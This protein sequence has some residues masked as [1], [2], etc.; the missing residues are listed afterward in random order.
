MNRGIASSLVA[1]VL[2][3]A[4]AT[5]AFQGGPS[6][7]ASA[8]IDEVRATRLAPDEYRDQFDPLFLA[9][10]AAVGPA[11]SITGDPDLDDRIRAIA[12]SR[13]Y[14]RQPEPS[15]DLVVVD[16]VRLQPPAAASWTALKSAAAAAGH[17]LVLRSGYRSH[18]DQRVI[19][20]GKLTDRSDAGIDRRLQTSAAPGY[21]KHHTGYAVDIT[22]SGWTI[23]SF[24]GSPGYTW[25][26][27][28]DFANAKAHGWI[29]SYPE[30]ASAQGPEPEPWELVWVG[31]TNILCGAF[32][33]RDDRTFCDTWDRSQ[34][35]DIEWL[36][37]E[38]ITNGCTPVRFCIDAPVTRAE[39]V[40]ML[41][42]F[43]CEPPALSDSPFLDVDGDRYYGIPVAWAS[44][45]QVTTGIDPSRFG[46]D[47]RSSRA[48]S[49]TFLW[50][51]AGR[52]SPTTPSPFA[53]V[54]PLSFYS[55]AVDWAH[56]TGVV[57]GTD[58]ITFDPDRPLTRGEAASLIRRLAGT[59]VVA[60]S[61]CTAS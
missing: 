23:F 10:L 35:D 7:S 19:F 13:G 6:A 8:F 22:Q 12:E 31:A 40:T 47:L 28:D 50:R 61:G 57:R 33:P 44:G 30:G 18:A 15:R 16:G 59:G 26:A 5:S 37:A 48:Q 32:D 56:G 46:P 45:S 27:A 43:S 38:G 20:T 60:R 42:R 17:S 51:L 52:P 58:P 53:D 1:V 25:L 39:L 24:E 41:W 2:A 55:A 34:H 11:P 3:A 14:R 36:H 9:G 49:V 54:A 29:P 4:T 21:S